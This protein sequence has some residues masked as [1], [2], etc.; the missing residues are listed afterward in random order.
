MESIN[1]FQFCTTTTTL[2]PTLLSTYSAQREQIKEEEQK[3]QIA[4]GRRRQHAAEIHK[5]VNEREMMLKQECK[6]YFEE[7]IKLDQEASE[8]CVCVCVCVCVCDV[9]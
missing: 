9:V 5:Q 7:G 6:E 8:R 4:E 3:H 2:L 1:T